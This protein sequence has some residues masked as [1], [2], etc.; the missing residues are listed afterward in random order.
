MRTILHSMDVT[1]MTT[2]HFFSFND[3]AAALL[4]IKFQKRKFEPKVIIYLA[5]SFGDVSDVYTI[6]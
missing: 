5:I 2:V 1:W 4:N 3:L 6:T